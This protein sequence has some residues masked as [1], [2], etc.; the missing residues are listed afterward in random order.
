M[1][2]DQEDDDDDQ[3]LAIYFIL[4]SVNSGIAGRLVGQAKCFRDI[5]RITIGR[6]EPFGRL[7]HA[8]LGLASQRLPSTKESPSSLLSI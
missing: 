8:L 1:V 4:F 3:G 7:L 6:L 2:G 5:D